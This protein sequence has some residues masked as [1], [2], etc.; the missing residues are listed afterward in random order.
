MK[1]RSLGVLGGALLIGGIVLG[2]GSSIVAHHVS[3]RTT[4]GG[5]A[6]V[7][8]PGSDVQG[9]FFGGPGRRDFPGPGYRPPGI[10]N[11]VPT[12]SPSPTG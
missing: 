1:Q 7:H 9:P 5:P 12:P 3:G 8:R 2:V 10:T 4:A 11:P 6:G